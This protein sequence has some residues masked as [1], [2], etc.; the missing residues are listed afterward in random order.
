MDLQPSS[1]PSRKRLD[2]PGDSCGP[3]D[4][5]LILLDTFRQ[6]E[7]LGIS[8]LARRT[9]L[10]KS[11]IHRLLAMLEARHFVER[12]GHKYKLGIHLIELGSRV[13]VVNRAMVESALPHLSALQH[14]TQAT[15]HLGL[16]DRG[17][18]LYLAKLK[19][20]TSRP[21][22]TRVGGRSPAY[23]T[24][25]GKALLAYSPDRTLEQLFHSP[26]RPY[27]ASTLVAPRTLLKDLHRTRARGLA[28][29]N[30]E[31]AQGLACLAAPILRNGSIV[32]AVSVSGSP[33]DI[34][35]HEPVLGRAAETIGAH[36]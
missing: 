36:I 6:D 27:T 16:L 21:S 7:V 12:C 35:K 2:E 4:R 10:P 33:R 22:S 25:I 34:Q 9:G 5:A 17:E 3:V 31:T 32:A 19:S 23:C 1:P 11:T 28:Y 20:R 18:V 8:V 26:L 29:D 13:L 30:E 24:A 15:V 14:Q